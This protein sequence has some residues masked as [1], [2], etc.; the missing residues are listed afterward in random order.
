MF[1]IGLIAGLV[2][3]IVATFL[4]LGFFTWRWDP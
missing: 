2:L 1:W 3:G 4:I